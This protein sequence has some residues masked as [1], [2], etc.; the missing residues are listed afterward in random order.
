MITTLKLLFAGPGESVLAPSY[1]ASPKTR[2]KEDMADGPE[3]ISSVRTRSFSFSSVTIPTSYS[4][5]EPQEEEFSSFRKDEP[6]P[7]LPEV[8]PGS[9]PARTKRSKN[10]S[11]DGV[12]SIFYSQKK[13][14]G[15]LL[16]DQ[17]NRSVDLFRPYLKFLQAPYDEA[18]YRAMM[19][20]PLGGLATIISRDLKRMN[21]F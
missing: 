13:D 5:E 14:E 11:W 6:I 3:L 21:S 9:A 8:V 17:R 7:A 18:A 16:E 15:S 1:D 10:A 4:Q 2:D 20:P 12:F 19:R